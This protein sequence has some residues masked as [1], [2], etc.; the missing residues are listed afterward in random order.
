[1]KHIGIVLYLLFGPVMLV[2]QIVILADHP[3]AGFLF[4][5][6]IQSLTGDSGALDDET[7]QQDTQPVLSE[8]SKA[9]SLCPIR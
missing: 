1:M 3:E 5:R 6:D 7:L 8:Q 4:A 9:F 2:Y